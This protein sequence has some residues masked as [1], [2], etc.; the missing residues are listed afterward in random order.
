VALATAAFTI[1]FAPHVEL[2]V[3]GIGLAI[4]AHLW[5]ER[6]SIKAWTD[7]E[8]L[9]LAPKG[10]LYFASAPLLEERLG[11]LLHEHP[12]ARRLVVHLHGLGRVDVTG[13]LACEP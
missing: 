1:A 7:R 12:R 3:A 10:V 9:H 2:A 11:D 4:G 8:T 13:A 6:M 5:R